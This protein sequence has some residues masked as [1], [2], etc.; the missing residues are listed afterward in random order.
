MGSWSTSIEG[1]LGEEEDDEDDDEEFGGSRSRLRD[2]F[3]AT[4]EVEEVEGEAERL[5]K[6]RELGVDSWDARESVLSS[7]AMEAGGLGSSTSAVAGSAAVIRSLCEVRR[8]AREWWPRAV[9]SS[10]RSGRA[11]A[12]KEASCG[13]LRKSSTASKWP[14][15]TARWSAVSPRL[16]GSLNQK[17]W[18][19]FLRSAARCR[20]NRA[21]RRVTLLVRAAQWS[22]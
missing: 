22:A 11:A 10:R 19:W 21:R 3:E 1:E 8:S 9:A 16:L 4:E 2:S 7:E 15:R 12:T 13:L 14:S 5:L 6:G 18:R 17:V 20:S